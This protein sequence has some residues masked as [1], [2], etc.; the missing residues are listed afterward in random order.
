LLRDIA[1]QIEA[2][3]LQPDFIVVT[4]D[5]AFSGNSKEYALARSFFQDLLSTTALSQDRLFLIPGNHDADRGQISSD[6]QGITDSLI[7]R[8]SVNAALTDSDTRRLMLARFHNYEKFVSEFFEHPSLGDDGC[9]YVCKFYVGYEQIALIGL[10]SAWMGRGGEADRGYL[11][12]GE[13]PVRR[14]LARAEGADFKIALLHHPFAWL[15]DFELNDSV[16]MLMDNCDFILHGHMHQIG[17]LQA[18]GPDSNAMVIAAGACYET[19]E[20]PNSYNWVRLD[21]PTRQGT[22]HLRTFADRRGGFWTKDVM[23]YRNV[24]DGRYQFG[25]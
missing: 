13:I 11:A 14:A 20:Y 1:K 25:W 7:D 17:L 2:G 10:N 4:G 19:R 16:A 21:L 23:N 8:P 3:K 18:R 22:V 12:I 15:R 5:I 24:P 9:F 6:V